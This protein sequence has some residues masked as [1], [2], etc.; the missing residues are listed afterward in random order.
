[1]EGKIQMALRAFSPSFRRKLKKNEELFKRFK[2][3]HGLS[4]HSNPPRYEDYINHW[5]AI[6]GFDVRKLLHEITQ[7]TLI[8]LV[9]KN[10]KER[11]ELK[12]LEAI[13]EKI[14]NSTIKLLKGIGHCLIFEAPEKTN[15]IMWNFLKEHMN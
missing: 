10:D 8:L 13:F 5:K 2:D 1:M 12:A 6:E 7:P 9:F 11:N 3:D 15:E 4:T 14:P